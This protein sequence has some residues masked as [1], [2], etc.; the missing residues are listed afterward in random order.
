MG[1][2]GRDVFKYGKQLPVL[3]VLH[4]R[5]RTQHPVFWVFYYTA[6]CCVVVLQVFGQSCPVL[7]TSTSSPGFGAT[8]TDDSA[9]W[10][11]Q[12]NS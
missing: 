8:G 10:I 1:L 11:V 5:G 4:P 9:C 12:L 6:A 7:G 2:A 3:R